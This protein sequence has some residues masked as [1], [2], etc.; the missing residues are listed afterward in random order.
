MKV[1]FIGESWL[2][3]C[4]R[5][6]K[7]ALARSLSVELD[8]FN[9]DAVFPNPRA[10]WLRAI[11][12]LLY[13]FYRRDFNRQVLARLRAFQPDVVL[14]YK[15]MHLHSDL[16]LAMREA[17]A[18]T[19][20][21]YPDAS[22]H[23]HGKS[24]RT[25]MGKYDLVISTKPH[26]KTFWGSTY[27]YGNTCMFV[28]QGYDPSLHLVESPPGPFIYDVV[29]VATYREE[30]GA[31]MREVGRALPDRGI[32]VA[33]GGYGW[34]SIRGELPP[35]WEFPGGVHGRAYLALLR[36]GKICVA[37]LT[38]EIIVS[39]R[40]Q[41]GDVDT[42]RTYELA[43][44]H[45]FFIH[46]RTEF[47]MGLYGPDEVPMFDNANELVTHIRRYLPHDALRATMASAAHSRAVPAYSLNTRAAEII[48]LIERRLE[49]R[50]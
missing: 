20:N 46:R 15:G 27:G 47:A 2:G 12:R 48:N 13:P 36:S 43:A 11:G 23:A 7:E 21:V 42:T 26:H 40:Q 19:V 32:R 4:A 30:Y 33:I 8:E 49:Q 17:G 45:C 44:A 1:L 28:P 3:S 29:L 6:L 16:V 22:P 9:E 14:T 18:L 24:H 5:S 50:L 31:L 34:E 39:G 25:A 38:R 41:P 37:P 10:R 35:H